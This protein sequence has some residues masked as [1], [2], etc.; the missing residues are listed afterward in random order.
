M[1]VLSRHEGQEVVMTLPDGRR[2]V[3]TVTA[4]TG[5]TVKMG[6]TAPKDVQIYRREVQDEIDSRDV[7]RRS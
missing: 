3:V 6:F 1:L 4:I 2:I 5:E 7:R